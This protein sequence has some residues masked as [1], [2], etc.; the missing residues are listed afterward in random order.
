MLRHVRVIFIPFQVPEKTDRT[1]RDGSYGELM[2][3]AHICLHVKCPI[4][5]TL[6][7]AI[8]NFSANLIT[9]PNIKF[10]VNP[11]GGIRDDKCGVKQKSNT[12]SVEER[13][14]CGGLISPE[15]NKEYVGHHITDPV[16]LPDLIKLGCSL[17]F[18]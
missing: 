14:F 9:I 17:Q 5:F 12:T 10:Q 2:Q 4:Y 11:S 6:F 1:R 7:E 13:L 16:I 8:W 3:L 15:T 18:S